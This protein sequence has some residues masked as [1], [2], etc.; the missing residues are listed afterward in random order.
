[1]FKTKIKIKYY[2]FNI[3]FSLKTS[4]AIIDH[5]FIEEN[6]GLVYSLKLF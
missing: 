3:Y 2:S 6:R 1:M 5:L 4:L